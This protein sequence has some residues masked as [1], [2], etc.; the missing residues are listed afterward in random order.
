MKKTISGK[1]V[2]NIMDVVYGLMLVLRVGFFFVLALGI[3]FFVR[4]WDRG[5]AIALMTA[6]ILGGVVEPALVG[7]Y[8]AVWK[9]IREQEARQDE[10]FK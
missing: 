10:T 2:G 1:T 8:D 9:D 6:A 5:A 4:G 3:F 7:A